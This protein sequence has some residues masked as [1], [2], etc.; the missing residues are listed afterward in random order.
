[1]TAF[2]IVKG[3]W[4][5]ELAME[6]EERYTRM[7]MYGGRSIYDEEREMTHRSLRRKIWNETRKLSRE[8]IQE[9]NCCFG[10]PNEVPE[11]PFN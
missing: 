4:R 1:M 3:L 2:E 7:Y 8:Q 10:W 9:I 6:D 11:L 5:L